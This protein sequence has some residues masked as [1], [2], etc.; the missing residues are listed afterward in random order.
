MSPTQVE[1]GKYA[2]PMEEAQKE[3][4]KQISIAQ[5]LKEVRIEFTKISWPSKEQAI[6]EFFAVLVLVSILTGII[7][8]I[9]KI[10]GVIT[11]IFMGRF[12]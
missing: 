2:K 1:L 10:L 9:D 11:N 5:F 3:T 8:L 6:R 12:Y 4:T 7:F